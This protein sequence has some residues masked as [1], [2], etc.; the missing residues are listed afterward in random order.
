[1]ERKQI[2]V[3]GLILFMWTMIGWTLIG[4]NGRPGW[5]PRFAE[6]RPAAAQSKQI[7]PHDS[8]APLIRF[9]DN[10]ASETSDVT[11]PQ[12]TEL[13]DKVKQ[14]EARLPASGVETSNDQ[15]QLKQTPGN[16]S[17]ESGRLNNA[18]TSTPKPAHLTAV[19]S[20]PPRRRH[21]K[22]TSNRC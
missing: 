1:M 16:A 18:V 17:G 21:E 20:S 6:S 22:Q 2:Q 9:P 8:S 13:T 12:V 7:S 10:Q 14:F 3:S 4:C 11:D 19:M 5:F 15:N